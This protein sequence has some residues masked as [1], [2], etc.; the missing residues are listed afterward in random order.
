LDDAEKQG[1][2]GERFS[3]DFCTPFNALLPW[4]LTLVSALLLADEIAN[5]RREA[6]AFKSVRAALRSENTSSTAAK[7]VFQ[8][9]QRLSLPSAPSILSLDSRYS[10]TTLSTSSLW[11]T[12]GVIEINQCH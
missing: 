1:E 11:M 2:N 8:K 10:T 5:L 12:C 7:M 3:D 4:I 6:Q 9:V